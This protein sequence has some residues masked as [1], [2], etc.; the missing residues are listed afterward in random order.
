[1]LDRL[2][3]PELARA[4]L[5]PG[6]RCVEQP[7]GAKNGRE[8][9]VSL[10]FDAAGSPEKGV[11]TFGGSAVRRFTIHENPRTLERSNPRTLVDTPE[12]R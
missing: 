6:E 7:A 3:H 8:I 4:V 5:E 1:V 11:R 10:R 9:P 12:W 2:G